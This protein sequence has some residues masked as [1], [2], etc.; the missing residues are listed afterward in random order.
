M[1]A[2]IAIE[3]V[4]LR[5]VSPQLGYAEIRLREVNLTGLRIEQSPD[6]RLSFTPPSRQDAQGRVWPCY[7]LQPEARAAIEAEISALW[8]R[9]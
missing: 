3:R 8:G 2:D 7:S 9:S 1:S 5:R 4:K 6:G